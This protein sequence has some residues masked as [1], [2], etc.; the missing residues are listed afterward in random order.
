MGI[1]SAAVAFIM[2]MRGIY[3]PK[4]GLHTYAPDDPDES[5]DED[6]YYLDSKGSSFNYQAKDGFQ[7]IDYGFDI[8]IKMDGLK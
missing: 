8:S 1:T 6:W 7:K 3:S 2:K 4:W 5:G